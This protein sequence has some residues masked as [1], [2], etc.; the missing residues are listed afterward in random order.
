MQPPLCVDCLRRQ[1]DGMV[2][3]HDEHIR[4]VQAQ[5]DQ[6]KERRVTEHG[7]HKLVMMAIGSDEQEV[8]EE[9]L[10]HAQ[11]CSPLIAGNRRL[12]EELERAKANKKMDLADFLDAMGVWADG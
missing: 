12:E 9:E 6:V 7:V 4:T 8:Q 1:I 5:I 2:A 10:R 3:A 11:E